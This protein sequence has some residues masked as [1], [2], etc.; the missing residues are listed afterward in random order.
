MHS[1]EQDILRLLGPLELVLGGEWVDPGGPNQR[2]LLAYLVL[3]EGEPVAIQTIVDA[4]WG[5]NASEGSVRSLRTYVSNLRRLLGSTVEIRG[6]QGAYR[7]TLHSLKTDIGLFRQRVAVADNIED[8]RG[9]AAALASAL[10][11]WRG[12]VLVDVDR[13]WVLDRSSILESQ[14]TNTVAR[15]AEATIADG[16]PELVISK[17]ER[18]VAEAVLD[19]RL[20]GILMLALY[21]SGRQA[22]ALA[23]YRRLRNMLVEE[24]GVEP[25]P[26]LQILEEQILMHD[27]TAGRVEP[28][29]LFPAPA[30]DLVGRSVE[31]EDL[32][33][34]TE[35]ARLLTLTGPGGVGKTRL[36]LEVGRRILADGTRPVFFADLSAV[37]DESAVDAVLASSVGVQPHPEAGPLVSLIEY[38]APRSAVL[39]VDNCEHVSDTVARAIASLVRS[40]PQLVVIATSRSSLFVDGEVTWRTPSLALPDRI[41]ASIEG[42]RRWPAVEL[43]L[44]RAPSTFELT[45]ANA[46]DVLELC[47]SLDGLPLALEIAASRL[48]SMTPTEILATLGSQVQLS[49]TAAPDD[50]RHATL[51]ATVSWSYELLSQQPRELLVRLGVMSGRFL[52]EDVL[53]VCAP[54]AENPEAVRGQL[55]ALVDQS[56]VM[57]ETSGTRTRY[58]LL[59]TI[60]R[61]S[62]AHLGTDEPAVRDR[63]ACHYAQL[64]TV[65]A[66]RLLTNEE[67]DAIVEM[68]AAHDNLRDAFRW[69]ME[70]GDLDSAS[71]I[72]I[73]LSD[74][75]YWRSRSEIVTWSRSVWENMAPSDVRWRAVSGTAA[76]GAWIES[77]FEDA[78][79]FAS[80]AA[81]AAGVVPSM[82]GYP[83]DV[84]ADVAL[85]RGDA[86][87]ALLHYTGVVLTARERGDLTREAWATY[88]VSVTNAVLGRLEEAALAAARALAIAR[89]TGNPTSLAFSLYAT[90]LAV[91]HD[92][93]QEA[94]AMFEEAVRMADSVRNE[95]MGGIARME[96]ASVNT[97]HGE[98]ATGLRGFAGVVDH[99]FRAAD[100]T[101]LRQTWRYLTSALVDV[102]LHEEAAVLAGA[103][104][105]DT[106]STLAH[107]HR[108]VLEV[109]TTALG[110]A[111]YR[112]L[113]IRGSIMSLP[114]LVTVSLDAINRALEL[115]ESG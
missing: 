4:I 24:L 78:V 90:G 58:R 94:R 108:R 10:A 36:A 115:D 86:S 60:R 26:E 109:I 69:A 67:G 42:L 93:P 5:D 35:R 66:A 51:Y 8:S 59:E 102:G 6:G 28:V 76:R 81:D 39:I 79:E 57:A 13:P 95:W 92:K 49:R 7:L 50:S 43:L 38:L 83:E 22:D 73:S 32:L 88:Y 12:P 11:L 41:D 85:Y 17:I 72:V 112:R 29:W 37:Q 56:L 63:H 40:C 113:T 84:L 34:H 2:A 110:D 80:K 14:R 107:P 52:F 105:V 111:Q 45:A 100:G 21:R 20:S 61:F 114:E 106:D 3:R 1:S 82:S 68:V 53:A 101:Q 23:V 99:W 44:R 25:G 103:L 48:G 98:T 104:L 46:D 96:L 54:G 19:E 97:A 87:T 70:N 62:V 55:S 65:Q 15:W 71:T 64:A 18:M 75:G 89:K 33:Q 47:R 9:V 91:K 77:R 31:I 74:G 16:E 27:V 30:S